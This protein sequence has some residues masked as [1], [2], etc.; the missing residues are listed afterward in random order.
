MEILTAEIVI[1][2]GIRPNASACT[3]CP[4]GRHAWDLRA[5]KAGS[6]DFQMKSP[7]LIIQSDY[8]TLKGVD[9]QCTRL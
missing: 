9:D 7:V 2:A 8:T 6:E 5:G 1:V 3:Y 4:T